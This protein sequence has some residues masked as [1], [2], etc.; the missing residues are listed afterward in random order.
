MFSI[1]QDCCD[2][3]VAALDGVYGWASEI[4]AIAIVVFVFNFLTKRLLKRLHSHFENQGRIWKDSFVR[5]LYIPLSYFIWFFAIIQSLDL[6]AA[7]IYQELPIDDRHMLIASGGLI[8]F[9]WFLLRW[10]SFVLK[11]LLARS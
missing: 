9:S 5:A 11:N 8:S 7:R 4:L 1:I 6:I 10:K 2:F 3:A